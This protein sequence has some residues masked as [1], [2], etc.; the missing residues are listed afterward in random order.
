MQAAERRR[1][2]PAAHTCSLAPSVP[3]VSADSFADFRMG[4]SAKRHV[5]HLLRSIILISPDGSCK[6]MTSG[7]PLR[8]DLNVALVVDLLRR[9]GLRQ[10]PTHG[11]QVRRKAAPC[12]YV[13]LRI[14]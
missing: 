13:G 6:H 12:S 10:L 4:V 7:T 9:L 1:S 14:R 3:T 11:R 8:C 5:R 2:C